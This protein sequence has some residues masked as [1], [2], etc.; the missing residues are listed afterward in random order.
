MAWRKRLRK[1]S[2]RNIRFNLTDSE[3]SFGRRTANHEFPNRDEPYSEDLG[4]KARE[5]SFEAFINGFEYDRQRDKLIDACEMRGPGKLVHPYYGNRQVVCTGCEVRESATEGG[6]ARFRL[7]FREAGTLI[8]PVSSVKPSGVLSSL[9]TEG[10]IQAQNDFS[11]KLEIGNKPQWVIDQAQTGVTEISNALERSTNF[12]TRN[13]DA[14]ADLAAS[15]NDLKDDIDGLI[16]APA[17]LAARVSNSFA[18]L[19]DAVFS[20]RESLAA[21]K[22]MFSFTSSNLKS[23]RTTAS[24]QASNG[25]VDVVNNFARRLAVVNAVQVAPL[26]TYTSVE[27]AN[28]ELQDLFD[29]INSQ[30]NF[31]GVP[32]DFYQL[33][34][35]L[36]Y[37]LK[38]AIPPATQKLP[39]IINLKVPATTNS[40]LMSYSLYGD[41]EKESEIVTR[42][43]LK[44]PG[45]IQGGEIVKVLSD[46]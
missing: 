29:A 45:F 1:A 28:A 15:I 38:A 27:D 5:F 34:H 44:Y 18:L 11:K 22:S 46:V 23:D 31:T 13:A 42:N 7:S 25:N 24:R 17:T 36:K 3:S 41:L 37:E 10:A 2:F 39:S 30:M 26:A 9:G 4:R 32:D 16:Q 8:F 19:K 14:V 20:P 40:I 33:L 12:I 43:D 35:Q 6:V 21:Y